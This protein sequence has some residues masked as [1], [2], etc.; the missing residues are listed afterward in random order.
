LATTDEII[1]QLEKDFPVSPEAEVP[2]PAEE[3]PAKETNEAAGEKAAR[4]SLDDVLPDDERLPKSMRG[5]SIAALVEYNR[6]KDIAA[7]Q[8]S[9]E[10]NAQK[11]R[12]DM[13]KTALENLTKEVAGVSRGTQQRQ[14]P[15]RPSASMRV[16]PKTV[17]TDADSYTDATINAARDA[18]REEIIPQV[19]QRLQQVTEEVNTLKRQA[20]NERVRSA[21]LAA[22]PENVSSADWQADS[23]VI[24]AYVIGQNKS[25]EDPQSYKDAAEWLEQARARRSKPG[26]SSAAPAATAPPPP[27]GNGKTAAPVRKS[28][29]NVS[30]HILGAF[31]EVTDVLNEVLKEVGAEG[32]KTTDGVLESMRGIRKYSEL[33]E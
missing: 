22:R 10:R 1:E 15:A 32:K 26:A 7:Q 31:N 3:T 25:I 13:F 23:G 27:V 5:K 9:Y 14:P 29:P 20:L 24:G 4:F 12:A 33:F 2:Q 18:A 28:R 11:E 16:D 17:Y 6:E 8:A 30:P 21:Y 19:D